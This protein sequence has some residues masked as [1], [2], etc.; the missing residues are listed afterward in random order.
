[1]ELL[2]F[3][4]ACLAFGTHPILDHVDFSLF[5]GERVCLVGRNGAGKSSFL[6]LLTGQQNLDDGQIVVNTGV[7]LSRLEQDPPAK[8]DVKIAD[9]IREGAGDLAAKLQ[10]FYTLSENLDGASDADYRLFEQLQSEL[11]TRD[12][13]S[14]DARVN[15]LCLQFDMNGEASLATLSGGWLRKAAL[16]RA[17]I[18]KPDI[19]L[20]DEPTNHLD[21]AAIQW[22]EQFLLNFSGAIMFIS[23]D[24]AFI[25]ALATRIVDLDRGQLTSHPG[26]YQEYLERK[27]K[28]LEDEQQHNALFDKKLAEEEVWIR[29]GIK[30][31]RT[32]NEGRVRALK[33]LRRERAERLETLGKVDFNI[34]QADRSGKLVFETKAISCSFDGKTIIDSLN[35]L[36]MRG[37]RIA[38]VGPNGVGK[39]TLI[40]LLL[41]DYQQDSGEIKR[42]TNIEVAYFDQHR[43]ALNLEATVQDN[44]ADGKQEISQNGK[45]RHVLSYLQD[46]LFPP[47]RARTP[48]KALSGGEKNRLLLAKLFAKPSNLLILDEPT[49]DLDVETLEL[50]EDILQQYQGTVLLVS[51]DREFVNNTV[52][53]SLLFAGAGRIVEITGGYDDVL[54]YQQRNADK[55]PAVQK[56]T[57]EAPAVTE[58]TPAQ[59]SV[60]SAKKLSYKEKRELEQLPALIEQLETELES[61][62]A[63]VNDAA[64]FKQSAEQT[65][66]TLNQLQQTESKLAQAYSRWE[67]LDA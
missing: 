55:A 44:V 51:H 64:F 42:G 7:V 8:M 52:T 23:H 66:N 6:K 18:A 4:Q 5:S 19:L 63:T 60:S 27:Q 15:D 24:R 67:E 53:S 9:F 21:V 39:S 17:L 38:L 35:L 33:A 37:D 22:L 11:D 2:R 20:L 13:W 45:T 43:M 57:K 32:R 62:Q 65:Q 47:A 29:Q 58:Q 12:G 61:L 34:E 48:V 36:V 40:K 54:A 3:Q 16:A 49:N 59:A 56:V 10:Q 41:G 31:R 46:F 1:M 14:L 28:M 30:A 26:N 25:R 50:L